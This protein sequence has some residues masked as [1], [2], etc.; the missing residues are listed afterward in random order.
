[1][2]SLA[3]LLVA[4]LC[5][6]V[7]P[8]LS[9]YASAALIARVEWAAQSER[10]ADADGGGHLVDDTTTDDDV[11][12]DGGHS[13]SGSS[14]CAVD[15]VR[16]RAESAATLT[17]PTTRSVVGDVA[18]AETPLSEAAPCLSVRTRPIPPSLLVEFDVETTMEGSGLFDCVQSRACWPSPQD[19]I[20]RS[21]SPLLAVA[22]ASAL[23]FLSRA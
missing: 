21:C 4:V 7:A 1:M 20:M 22:A 3:L 14:G 10:A 8:F 2:L 18:C 16:S 9:S 23:R 6:R 5:D 11:Y 12:S 15:D 17:A 13:E 19:T